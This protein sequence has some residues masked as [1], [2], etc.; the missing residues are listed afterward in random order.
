MTTEQ[1]IEIDVTK[2]LGD[3]PKNVFEALESLN[4]ATQSII[5]ALLIIKAAVEYPEHVEFNQKRM[6]DYLNKFC[7]DETDTTG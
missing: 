5:D 6:T 7:K 3:S 2:I 1:N 4:K